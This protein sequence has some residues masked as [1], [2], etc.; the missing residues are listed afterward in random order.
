MTV[1]GIVTTTATALLDAEEKLVLA[2][3][4][5]SV[6]SYI[7][8][9]ATVAEEVIGKLVGLSNVELALVTTIVSHLL[10]SKTQSQQPSAK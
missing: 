6:S 3:P 9:A 7:M 2:N 5:A 4:S 8:T 10:Q 1:E